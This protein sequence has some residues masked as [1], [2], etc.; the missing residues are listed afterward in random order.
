MFIFYSYG[1][2]SI[3]ISPQSSMRSGLL[4][5][6]EYSNDFF[7]LSSGDKYSSARVGDL[8]FFR[9]S[10]SYLLSTLDGASIIRRG[11]FTTSVMHV[12]AFRL[13]L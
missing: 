11:S 5:T 2:D 12:K 3:T 13:I 1:W 4:L 8:F 9:A 6:V 7:A 10:N